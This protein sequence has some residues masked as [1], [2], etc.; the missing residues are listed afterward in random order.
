[1]QRPLKTLKDMAAYA[2]RGIS[3]ITNCMHALGT[4]SPS[5]AKEGP[6]PKLCGGSPV[7][8]QCLPHAARR[9]HSQEAND[10]LRE[11]REQRPPARRPP[12]ALRRGGPL[13]R[14]GA[15]E[16]PQRQPAPLPPGPHEQLPDLL[17]VPFEV[18]H[19]LAAERV[20][21]QGIGTAPEHRPDQ[22]PRVG[23]AEERGLGADDMQ[24]RKPGGVEGARVCAVRE[25]DL[26]ARD[27]AFL[28]RPQQRRLR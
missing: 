12:G 9:E 14:R 8:R 10:V 1:M 21:P 13:A 3:N 16:Q 19:G 7:S 20:A 28:R 5:R 4:A 15:G 2:V 22:P 26:H 18:M 27:G 6:S 24:G 17:A 11:L 25:E 23:R